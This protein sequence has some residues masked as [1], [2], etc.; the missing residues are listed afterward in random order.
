MILGL[1]AVSAFAGKG[2][3]LKAMAMTVFGLM[4]ATVGTDV[5]T[6]APRFTFNNIDLVDGIS[7]LLLAMATLRWQ[8]LS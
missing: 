2:Q 6:G 3:V 1:T 7:F 4:I 8:K 5:I